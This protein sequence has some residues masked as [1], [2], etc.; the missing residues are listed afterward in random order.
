MPIFQLEERNEIW[1]DTLRKLW[2]RSVRATHFFLSDEEIGKIADYIPQALQEVPLLIVATQLSGQPA[3]FMGIDG[4]KLEM[5]FIAPEERGKGWGRQLVEY[6]IRKHSID[7]VGVNEQ[8][9]Q[10]KG[11]YERLGFRVYRRADLDEQGNPYPILY[12]RLAPL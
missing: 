9:P 12:M 6:G 7:E 8:N 10:A 5:L 11:F 2:E 3:G 1:I 4:K